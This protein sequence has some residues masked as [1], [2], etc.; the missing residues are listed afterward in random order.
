MLG[1]DWDDAI[2]NGSQ[3]VP[4]QVLHS[5]M[6]VP[7]TGPPAASSTAAMGKL[8]S[9]ST[10]QTIPGQPLVAGFDDI[11]SLGDRTTGPT[12]PRLDWIV[13]GNAPRTG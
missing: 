3:S 2:P 9:L 5:A 1:W 10:S 7:T 4:L 6:R 8:T 12:A 11:V 13:G